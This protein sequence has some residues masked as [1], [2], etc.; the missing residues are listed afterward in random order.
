MIRHLILTITLGTTCTATGFA[1]LLDADFNDKTVNAPIGQGGAAVGE[2]TFVNGGM[3]AIVRDAPM[4]SNCLELS[5]ISSGAGF[6]RFDFVDLMEVS[7]GHVTIS[8]DLWFAEFDE[9]T[10]GIRE[11]ET[12]FS[13]F[14]QLTFTSSGD[15]EYAD[16]NSA[17]RLIGTYGTGY[18]VPVRLEFDMDARRLDVWIEEEPLVENEAFG[19]ADRG[20]GAIVIGIGQDPEALGTFYVDNILAVDPSQLFA[21]GFESGTTDRWSQAAP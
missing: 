7:T 16:G 19:I 13:N 11:S 18:A 5:D 15:I 12:F 6:A 20:V 14:A 9:F 2:P 17:T 1:A 10:F 8:A 4:A 3:T 21:D